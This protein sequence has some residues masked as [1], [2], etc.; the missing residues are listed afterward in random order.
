MAGPDD[1]DTG[2]RETPFEIPPLTR[3]STHS[4]KVFQRSARAE[5]HIRRA[6]SL[7]RGEL[8]GAIK[9]RRQ[10]DHKAFICEEALAF[11][12]RHYHRLDDRRMVERLFG[13]LHP[14]CIPVLLANVRGFPPDLRE[15]IAQEVLLQLQK[16]LLAEGDRSDFAQVRFWK[17]LRLLRLTACGRMRDYLSPAN[18]LGA[19]ALEDVAMPGLSPEKVAILSRYLARLPK[20]ESKAFIMRYQ[21]GLP[22]GGDGPDEAG[23]LTIASHFGVSGRTVRTWLKRAVNTLRNCYKDDE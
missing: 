6:M 19:D 3:V 11:L 5:D 22:I 14:R 23:D 16:L 2:D 12:I 15:D 8:F 10:A 18:V 13:A 4:R 7:S 1:V 17:Y 21:W 9:I 20:N